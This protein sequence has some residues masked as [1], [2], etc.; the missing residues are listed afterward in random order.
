MPAHQD[1]GLAI[2][3][4]TVLGHQIIDV[5]EFLVVGNLDRAETHRLSLGHELDIFGWSGTTNPCTHIAA[6]GI[7]ASGRVGCSRELADGRR[8]PVE[9]IQ[10]I[11]SSVVQTVELNLLDD[12]VCRE[13]V[14]YHLL[15][16]HQVIDIVQTA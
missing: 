6:I 15:V 5:T 12:I 7:S 3:N 8:A 16:F 9:A 2:L 14:K 1:V 4:L 10:I 11:I 13:D